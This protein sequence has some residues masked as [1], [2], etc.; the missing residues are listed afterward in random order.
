MRIKI[1]CLLLCVVLLAGCFA[2]C[3]KKQ[4]TF[5]EASEAGIAFVKSN[6]L[7]TVSVTADTGADGKVSKIKI[8]GSYDPETKNGVFSVSRENNDTVETLKDCIKICGGDAYF[9]ISQ[10]DLSNIGGLLGSGLF[11][12]DY[13]I[14]DGGDEQPYISEREEAL[15]GIEALLK[16]FEM[17][18]GTDLGD[19]DLSGLD[20]S[21]LGYNGFDLN[22]LDLSDVDPSAIDLSVYGIDGI[23]LSGISNEQITA[24]LSNLDLD[25]IMDMLAEKGFFDDYEEEVY[26][27]SQPVSLLGSLSAFANEL[28]GKY[29]KLK[30]PQ[31]KLDTLINVLEAAEQSAYEKAQKLD[32]EESYP[33]VVKYTKDDARDLVIS[34]LDGIKEGK[35]SIISEVKA[36]VLEYVSAEEL[37]KMEKYAGKSLETLLSES[38]DGFFE[39]NKAE[40]IDLGTEETFT[41]VQKLAYETG[42]SYE[43]VTEITANA[44]NEKT[45]SKANISVTVI[46]ADPDP[47]FAEKCRVEDEKIFDLSKFLDNV[48]TEI[49]L[50]MQ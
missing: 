5:K 33:Y 19:I 21:E 37:E 14:F 32:P 6:G 49:S 8:E 39:N 45:A 17:F 38:M 44:D 24:F 9:K 2:G 41:C 13:E 16:Q 43:C 50:R 12:Y 25:A 20:L 18:T 27:E 3:M 46:T 28:S 40:D 42:V 23:D 34:V 4:L 7:K 1:L 11:T 47:E 26:E 30:L 48:S 10:L 31:N 36:I 29:I 15:S 35:N 22:K